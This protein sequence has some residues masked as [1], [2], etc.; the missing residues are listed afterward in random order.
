MNLL[1]QDYHIFQNVFLNR[2]VKNKQLNSMKYER[3]EEI[4]CFL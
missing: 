2:I 1:H 3:A 4:T